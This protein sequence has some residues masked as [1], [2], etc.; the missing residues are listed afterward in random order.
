MAYTAITLAQLRAE[1]QAKYESVPFWVD[2]EAN[3]F[4]NE[5]LRTWNSLTGRWKGTAVL[6]TTPSDAFYALPQAILYRAR[7]LF[8]SQ[9]LTPSS[10]TDLS[11]GRPRFRQETTLSGGDVPTRPT[12]WA[13]I[14]L[15]LIVIWPADAVGHNGL[16]VSGVAQTPVLTADGDFVNLPSADLDPILG[17][18]LHVATLKKGGAYFSQ[19][20]HYWTEF[21]AAAA[22]QNQLITTSQ[23]Y[24]RWMGLDRR[25][26]K[27][28]VDRQL[29]AGVGAPPSGG[30][31]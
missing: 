27:P 4:L 2:A 28:V 16:T 25:D 3:L 29:P 12:V 15:R 18:A 5:A 23:L 19:S 7:V 30:Q 26:L 21:L 31:G 14:S 13:P 10:Y 1:L 24:R 22:E 8:N 17:Y 9:P 6:S 11:A 20:L